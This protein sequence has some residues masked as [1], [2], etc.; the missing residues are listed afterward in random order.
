MRV[1]Q[2]DPMQG[3][4]RVSGP[5]LDIWVAASSLATRVSLEHNGAAV[6][7]VSWLRKESDMQHINLPELDVVLKGMN[8]ALMWKT[9]IQHL[10]TDSA[11][12]HKWIMDTLMGKTRVNTKVAS[13]M[14]IR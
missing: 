8:L 2:E 3:K 4:W 7:D 1:R 14:L 6:E 9:T 12:V 5:K 13:E 10:H 11:C